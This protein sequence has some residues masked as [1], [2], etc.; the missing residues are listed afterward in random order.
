MTNFGIKKFYNSLKT[1]PNFFLQH[2]KNK[3]ISSLVKFVATKRY[4]NN[5]F[6]TISFVAVFGSGIRGLRSGIQDPGW[7]KIR[8]R[9]KHPGSATL[10]KIS[11]KQD[12]GFNKHVVWVCAPCLAVLSWLS[13]RSQG[14]WAAWVGPRTGP[15]TQAPPG[16]TRFPPRLDVCRVT[17]LG[18]VWF[19]MSYF[20]RC[21]KTVDFAMAASQ[22]GVCKESVIK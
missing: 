7:V 17:F 3:I 22:N 9:D 8:I 6:S 19:G 16:T 14:G 15:P 18:D 2:F 5:F 21:Y 11:Q 10:E 12:G 20:R 13:C 4:D 1:G